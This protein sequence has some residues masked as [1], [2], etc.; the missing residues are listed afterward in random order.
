[1][2]VFG[3]ASRKRRNQSRKLAKTGGVRIDRAVELADAHLV[4]VAGVDGDDVRRTDQVVPVV[5]LDIGASTSHRIDAGHAHGDDFAL[6]PHLEAQEGL[7]VGP[8]LL[9]VEIGA[10]GQGADRFQHRAHPGFRPGDRAVDPF[11]GEQQR[12][13]DRMPLA[14]RLQ[15]GLEFRIRVERGELVEGGDETGGHGRIDRW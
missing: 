1:M 13:E 9:V 6:Q 3:R 2:R 4:I 14:G 12:A 8:A 11:P 7:D 15:A 10:A 5:R